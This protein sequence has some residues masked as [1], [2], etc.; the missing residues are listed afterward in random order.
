MVPDISPAILREYQPELV[1]FAAEEAGRDAE[2]VAA[3]LTAAG[4]APLPGPIHGLPPGVLL[5]LGATVRLRRWEAAG[6][7]VHRSAGLPSARAALGL[8]IRT[9][10]AA[11]ANPA[12]MAA[13][14]TLGRAVFDLA[15]TRFA[16]AARTELGAD[17]VL[18]VNDEA[19][20]VEAL[21]QFL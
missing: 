12:V 19:T 6:L 10:E 21:A 18:D 3:L 16:W 4:L 7:W 13:A 15:V 2:D 14:G 17:V 20:L 9:L 11:A 5:D 1:R 8:V